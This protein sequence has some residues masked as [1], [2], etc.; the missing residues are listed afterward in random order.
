LSEV[1]RLGYAYSPGSIESVST[2]IAV[3]VRDARAVVAALGVVMPRGEERLDAT[4]AS[5]R[6]AASGIENALA[7][8]RFDSHSMG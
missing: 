3:P 4:V 2:G 8:S 7:A 1:R 6:K 5:L